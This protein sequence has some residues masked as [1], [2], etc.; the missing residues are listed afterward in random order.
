MN[1]ITKTHISILIFNFLLLLFIPHRQPSDQAPAKEGVKQ[2]DR[3]VF[4][5]HFPT[6]GFRRLNSSRQAFQPIILF[7]SGLSSSSVGKSV[8]SFFSGHLTATFAEGLKC[9]MRALA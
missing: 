6:S 2:S 9:W 3:G 7:N 4:G 5:G 1:V 8:S